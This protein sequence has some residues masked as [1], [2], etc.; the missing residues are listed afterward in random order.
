MGASTM[1]SQPESTVRPTRVGPW[2]GIAFAVLF[3]AGFLVFPTP[4]DEKDSAQW[5][6]W[7]TDS[8][9]RAG[10]VIGAY[11][12]VFALLA[13]VWFMWDLNR[14][15]RDRGG[16]MITF[17]TVFVTLAL[18]SALVRAAIPG[19]KLFGS[20]PVPPGADIARQFDNVGF[21][22]LLVAGALAAG[23]FTATA[24][25]LA[26]RDAIL[27]GWL[28]IAGYVVAVLMLAAGFFLPFVFF[29]LWVLVTSIVLV[30]RTAEST[31]ATS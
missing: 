20:T 21:A 5:S 23:A 12:M 9:H 15:L 19:G 24:S 27:P 17:G 13:F 30:R 2:M 1:N 22:V 6:R 18:V 10:A 25:H 29:P 16:M 3:V 14:R 28:T 8:G 26:R 31:P 7:W 4:S 11:L